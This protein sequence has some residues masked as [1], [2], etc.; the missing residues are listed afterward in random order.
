M[1]LVNRIKADGL[2]RE[3]IFRRRSR[4]NY[5]AKNQQISF[6]TYDLNGNAAIVADTIR[7]FDTLNMTIQSDLLNRDILRDCAF[8]KNA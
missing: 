3:V 4:P 5:N 6:E 2:L 8:E 1:P 7:P